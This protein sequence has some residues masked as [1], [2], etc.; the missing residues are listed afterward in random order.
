MNWEAIGAISEIVGALTVVVTLIYLAIQVR[1]SRILAAAEVS[2]STVEAYSRFRNGILQNVEI[3]RA[4]AKANRGEA[5]DDDEHILLRTLVDDF[6]ITSV[7]STT[8]TEQWNSFQEQSVDIEYIRVI[9]GENPGLAQYWPRFRKLVALISEEYAQTV[10][11]IIE[12]N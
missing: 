11:R 12:R 9:F 1:M 5:L 4:I 7:M 6:F 2:Y 3:S 8:S 10:D